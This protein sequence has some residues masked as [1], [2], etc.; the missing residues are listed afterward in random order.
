MLSLYYR[1]STNNF[2]YST[3]KLEI[4][5]PLKILIW[6]RKLKKFI[7]RK[8]YYLHLNLILKKQNKFSLIMNVQYG[9]YFSDFI[10]IH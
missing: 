4:I 2:T 5:A 7:K 10:L 6:N 3:K 9:L 1:K 8:L